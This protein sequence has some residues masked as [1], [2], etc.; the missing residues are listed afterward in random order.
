MSSFDSDPLTCELALFPAK[1]TSN[2]ARSNRVFPGMRIVDMALITTY[3]D[4]LMAEVLPLHYLLF[5]FLVICRGNVG[6]EGWRFN[7]GSVPFP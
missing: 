3:L 2:S 5:L 1:N 7:V 4:S 6:W